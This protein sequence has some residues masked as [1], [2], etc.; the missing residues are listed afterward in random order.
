MLADVQADALDATVGE[1]QAQH[2]DVIGVEA[3]VSRMPSRAKRSARPRPMPLAAPV[4]TATLPDDRSP[5]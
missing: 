3:D 5:E 2:L 1:L 4:T